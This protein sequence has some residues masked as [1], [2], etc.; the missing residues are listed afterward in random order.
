MKHFLLI[1]LVCIIAPLL[2]GQTP[3]NSRF[4]RHF[5][6]QAA[7]SG[8]GNLTQ[9]DLRSRSL[10]LTAGLSPATGKGSPSCTRKWP[11]LLC[12]TWLL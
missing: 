2:R 9:A 4:A 11:D 8:V 1:V 12:G 3:E 7:Y 6:L 5:F 10:L